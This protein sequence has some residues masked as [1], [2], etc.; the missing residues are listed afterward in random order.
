MFVLL[1]CF[2]VGRRRRRRRGEGEDIRGSAVTP[3]IGTL[4]VGEKFF[5]SN[6]LISSIHCRPVKSYITKILG[7]GRGGEEGE[8]RGMRRRREEGRG[9][10]RK[11][12]RRGKRREGSGERGEGRETYPTTGRV[13][14]YKHNIIR[15]LWSLTI[16]KRRGGTGGEGDEGGEGLA[17]VR[18]CFAPDPVV[19]QHLPHHQPVVYIY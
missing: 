15:K 11:N 14:V 18:H 2:V 6:V 4:A 3:M 17:V 5:F 1:I 8:G 13:D 10:E 19:L 16:D 7:E 9:R 12:V